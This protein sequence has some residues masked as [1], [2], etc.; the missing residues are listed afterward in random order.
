MENDSDTFSITADKS[1][2]IE[3]DPIMKE[4]KK[5]KGQKEVDTINKPTRKKSHHLNFWYGA[6][7]IELFSS[8][9]TCFLDSVLCCIYI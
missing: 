4:K 6:D 9:K 2:F 7:F 8:S 3:H 5:K 1:I